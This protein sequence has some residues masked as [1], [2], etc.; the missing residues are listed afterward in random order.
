MMAMHSRAS[1]APR[2]WIV[3][4]SGASAS[5]QP[6]PAGGAGDSG[7]GPVGRPLGRGRRRQHFPGLGHPTRGVLGEEVVEQCAARARHPHDEER[8]S[9]LLRADLGLAPAV[10]LQPE[11]I[12]EEADDV[13]P[14]DDA[15][16]EGEASL[17]FEALEHHPER[18][19]KILFA[20]VLQS[21]ATSGGGQQVL[22]SE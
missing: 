18:L 22:L 21:R 4:N 19:A 20:E 3:L 16:D 2:G 5:N 8:L 1:C 14:G 17:V 7:I 15:A 13:L 9:H 11:T 10:L 12:G 6:K